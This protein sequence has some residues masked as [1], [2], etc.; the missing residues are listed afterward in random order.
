MSEIESLRRKH[1]PYEEGTESKNKWPVRSHLTVLA[2]R[3]I[4]DNN[5]SMRASR[6]IERLS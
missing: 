3:P 6:R 1:F 2:P 4:Y 5:N